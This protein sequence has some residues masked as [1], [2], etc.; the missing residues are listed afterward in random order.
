MAGG[1]QNQR[2]PQNN[3]SESD[4][5]E[6]CS[7]FSH[8]EEEKKGQVKQAEKAVDKRKPAKQVEDSYDAGKRV[9]RE[10]SVTHGAEFEDLEDQF[11]TDHAQDQRYLVMK[12]ASKLN[13]YRKE[14]EQLKEQIQILNTNLKLNKQIMSMTVQNT[15]D[16]NLEESV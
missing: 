8:H 14:N 13:F 16:M 3:A 10:T 7:S 1:A 2:Q 11:F 15:S 9:E 4:S 6:S 12:Q 5:S